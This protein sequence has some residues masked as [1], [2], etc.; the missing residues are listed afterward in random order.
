[1]FPK[2]HKTSSDGRWLATLCP[3]HDDKSPSAWIDTRRQLFG[4][5]ACNFKPMD[6]INLYARLHG[7]SDSNAVVAMAKELQVWG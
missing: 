3:F 2:V 4:C 5:N 7:M 1:M 6:A